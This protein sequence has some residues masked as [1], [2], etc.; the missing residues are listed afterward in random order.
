M[1]HNNRKIDENSYCMLLK[2]C[3]EKLLCDFCDKTFDSRYSNIIHNAHHIVIP[4]LKQEL[5]QCKECL[6]HFQTIKELVNHL[7]EKHNQ[8]AALQQTTNKRIYNVPST[9][10]VS[11][12][13]NEIINISDDEDNIDSKHDILDCFKHLEN[14]PVEKKVKKGD[15]SMVKGSQSHIDPSMN[16]EPDTICNTWNVA[17]DKR[18]T[19]FN[20]YDSMKDI[21]NEEYILPDVYYDVKI[22][23]NNDRKITNS[24]LTNTESKSMSGNNDGMLQTKLNKDS[25]RFLSINYNEL[26]QLCNYKCKY[27]PNVNMFPSRYALT[28]H[29]ISHLEIANIPPSLCLI[30]DTYF[31]PANLKKHIKERHCNIMPK[32]CKLNTCIICNFK[33]RSYKKH[34]YN[35]HHS[36]FSW[37][38]CPE[39]ISLSSMNKFHGG[40]ALKTIYHISGSDSDIVE[41]CVKCFK[42]MNNSNVKCIKVSI[43]KKTGCQL[44]CSNCHDE[45][46]EINF[47]EKWYPVFVSRFKF[48]EDVKKKRKK[49]NEDRLRNIQ[50][51]LKMINKLSRFYDWFYL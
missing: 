28:L 41:L 50:M 38:S 35:Y 32:C 5:H 37:E 44:K 23:P 4:L 46:V 33:Y 3:K 17:I 6:Y 7:L 2:K 43:C 49:T 40:I 9:S 16:V 13:K 21:K 11:T 26:T 1:R 47:V 24:Q 15:T 42:K 48:E 51:R 45:F 18:V 8:V 19:G 27:C 30:C 12:K 31:S 25:K 39:A 34:L 36:L 14:S 29:Q 10:A 20:L 22:S